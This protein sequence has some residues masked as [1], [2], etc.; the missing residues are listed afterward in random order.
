MASNSNSGNSTTYGTVESGKGKL[1]VA[2]VAS[3]TSTDSATSTDALLQKDPKKGSNSQDKASTRAIMKCMYTSNFGQPL[4]L[5]VGSC[6]QELVPDIDVK[7]WRP[8]TI[9]E[10]LHI[11][12]K[13][14]AAHNSML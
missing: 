9:H 10:T 1:P 12:N 7:R 2:S 5:I 6:T 11:I 3:R 14:M 4:S 8:S 13:P